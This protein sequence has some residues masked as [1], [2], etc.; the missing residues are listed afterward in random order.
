MEEYAFREGPEDGWWTND[1]RE[2][3]GLS[4][5]EVIHESQDCKGSKRIVWQAAGLN[6][7]WGEFRADDHIAYK[8][9]WLFCLGNVLNLSSCLEI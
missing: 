4:L 9:T 3:T 5:E 2:W 7:S 6:G 1:I 8:S